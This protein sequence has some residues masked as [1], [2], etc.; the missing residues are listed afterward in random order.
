MSP[1]DRTTALAVP[2]NRRG[3]NRITSSE[4]IKAMTTLASMTRQP[5]RS[6]R[7][8]SAR[9]MVSALAVLIASSASG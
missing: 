7:P 3:P 6:D 1:D 5:R 4:S 8:T 9:S 2:L